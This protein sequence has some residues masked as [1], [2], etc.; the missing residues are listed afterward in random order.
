VVYWGTVGGV[1]RTVGGVLGDLKFKN[2]RHLEQV[3]ILR[4]S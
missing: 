1:L 4:C 2:L 3:F